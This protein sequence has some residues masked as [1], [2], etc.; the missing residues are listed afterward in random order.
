MSSSTLRDRRAGPPMAEPLRIL[1]AGQTGSGKSSV[2]NALS[3]E[4]GAIVDALPPTRKAEA[5]E[6]QQL[7]GLA[8]S[9]VIDTPGVG[10]TA[11][12]HRRFSE[13]AGDCDLIVWTVNAIEPNDA[14]D[15]EALDAV[16][17]HFSERPHRREPP[18]IVAL[19]HIDA[20]PPAS[21]WSPPY[22]TAT[23]T[24]E[25]ALSIRAAMERVAESLD[26]PLADIVP[27]SVASGRP[28]YN[29]EQL[30]DRITARVPE[31][32]RA[33]L[34]RLME[35]AAPRWSVT[36]LGKQAG[37]AVWSAARAVTP[38]YFKSRARPEPEE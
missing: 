3:K 26:L 16:R 28:P 21:E 10:T 1:V 24:S 9:L 32:Q 5:H 7:A 4:E 18:I 23:P 20:L 19:T 27:V 17:K 8:T 2:V 31:A 36:R 25:K 12:E 15:R 35:D 14:A 33:Q 29:V 6:L 11:K 37:S 22:D 38:S 34:L 13:Q 30:I